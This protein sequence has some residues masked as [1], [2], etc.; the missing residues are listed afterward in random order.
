M[1]GSA[2]APRMC[3]GVA[4]P[5]IR[6]VP[7]GRFSPRR[8]PVV[9]RLCHAERDFFDPDTTFEIQLVQ[10]DTAPVVVMRR[11]SSESQIKSLSVAFDTVSLQ[12]LPG[13]VHQCK[14]RPT[15]AVQA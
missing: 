3:I 11:Q 15:T 5:A 14:R 12:E 10:A 13:V 4:A 9:G 1:E 7:P 6:H 2:L 8:T